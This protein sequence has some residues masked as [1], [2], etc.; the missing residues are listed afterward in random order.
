MYTKTLDLL[1]FKGTV[2][3]D[4]LPPVFSRLSNPS[5]HLIDMLKHFRKRIRFREDIRIES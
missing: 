3:R 5:K 2:S 1:A 4:F